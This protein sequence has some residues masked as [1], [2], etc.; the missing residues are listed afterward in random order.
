MQQNNFL[1]NFFG[2]L[3]TKTYNLTELIDYL[4]LLSIE[5]INAAITANNLKTPEKIPC[6][7]FNLSSED[8]DRTMQVVVVQLD[9]QLSSEIGICILRYS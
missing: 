3:C 4:R 2:I 7:T 9:T 1:P 8:Y 6:I 5:Y